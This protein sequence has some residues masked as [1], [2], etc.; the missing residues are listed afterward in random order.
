QA[1]RAGY[2]RVSYLL[3]EHRFGL[4]HAF[5]IRDDLL[6]YLHREEAAE[7]AGRDELA[8]LQTAAFAELVREDHDRRERVDK[9]VAAYGLDDGLVVGA[10][11]HLGRAEIDVAPV[12]DAGADDECPIGLIVG[13]GLD[14]GRA[15][16]EPLT[17]GA[18]F[19]VEPRVDDLHRRA[20]LDDA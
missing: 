12:L 20:G 11:A 1:Q 7:R 10:H 9:G 15:L 13:V 19:R 18:I 4:T 16:V 3:H 8:G 17:N 6:A 5:E 14:E 2:A